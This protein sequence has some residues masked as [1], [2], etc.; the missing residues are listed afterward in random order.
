MQNKFLTN[1]CYSCPLTTRHQ[2]KIKFLHEVNSPPNHETKTWEMSHR[3][4]LTFW[5]FPA[6]ANVCAHSHNQKYLICHEF[7]KMMGVKKILISCVPSD[8]H[9]VLCT[10]EIYSVSCKYYDE[11]IY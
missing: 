7:L 1:Q 5:K 8:I 9:M 6:F 2:I 11:A 3:Y 10:A 4:N